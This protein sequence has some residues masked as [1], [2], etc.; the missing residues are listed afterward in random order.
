MSGNSAEVRESRRI[1]GRDIRLQC[2]SYSLPLLRL[3]YIQFA[4]MPI[5]VLS[6][7]HACISYQRLKRDQNF[8]ASGKCVNKCAFV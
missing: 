4:C 5:G 8:A 3:G 2:V 7:L 1:V 6:R